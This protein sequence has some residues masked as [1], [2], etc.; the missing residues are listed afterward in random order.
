MNRSRLRLTED[1]SLT[2]ISDV[3][4]EGYHSRHGAIQESNHVF[5]DAGLRHQAASGDHLNVLEFGF[6]TGLNAALTWQWVMQLSDVTIKY[7]AVEAYPIEI[8][9]A[10]QLNYSTMLGLEDFIKLHEAP[11]EEEIA[12]SDNFRL[13]KVQEDFHKFTFDIGFDLIYYDAF[14][15]A[16]QPMLWEEPILAQV[17]N[18][19][20]PGAALVTYCAKGSF[21]RALKK[22]GFEVEE[23]P[24]PP[25]KREMTRAIAKIK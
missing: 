11:W 2:I 25:G 5:I 20:A 21:K 3:F 9:E 24:G 22:V 15:P 18:M 7:I 14:A 16:C 1:G 4:G 13:Q 12:L 6:G 19:C 23:L 17:M 10:Q 8:A